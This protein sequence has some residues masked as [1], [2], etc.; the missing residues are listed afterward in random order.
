MI[1][2]TGLRLNVGIILSNSEG[3]LFWEK[4]I[5]SPDSWQ[6]PQGGVKEQESIEEA[7]YRELREEIGLE[8]ENV[9]ILGV[10]SKWL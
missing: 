10:T 2:E 4:R 8:P 9:K 7:M 1:D 5:G 3:R 6:F